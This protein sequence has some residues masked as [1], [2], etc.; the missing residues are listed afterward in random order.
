M[1]INYIS[2][3]I[4]PN[5]NHIRGVGMVTWYEVMEY[6]RVHG[7]TPQRK[8]EKIFGRQGLQVIYRFMQNGTIIRYEKVVVQ[9]PEG[10]K[11]MLVRLPPKKF[12]RKRGIIVAISPRSLKHIEKYGSYYNLPRAKFMQEYLGRKFVDVTKL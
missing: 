9:T 6:L 4:K 5:I 12:Q 1:H 10:P 11:E 3:I 8:I 7:P 2:T